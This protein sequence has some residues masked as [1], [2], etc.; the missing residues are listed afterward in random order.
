MAA[1]V[2]APMPTAP[3]RG[4]GGT[5]FDIDATA[6]AAAFAL[7]VT[8]INT[9]ASFIDTKAGEALAAALGGDLPSMAG[10]AL[11][12]LR[13]N[14]GETA[15]E[16]E[17]V[18]TISEVKSFAPKIAEMSQIRLAASKNILV[19]GAN[20]AFDVQGGWN[21]TITLFGNRIL[22][23]PTNGFSGLMGYIQVVQGSTGSRTLSFGSYYEFPGG[24]AP[25]LTATPGAIDVLFYC[26]I[27]ATRC[28]VTNVLDI[29]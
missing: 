12:F 14:A 7:L 29:S 16:F 4:D 6:F 19:D 28:L 20:V 27:S 9:S 8:E 21:A 17:D 13:V 3:D 22:D 11:Q 15:A 18:A 23:N 1:P 10:K 5:Q 24:T 25:V 26:F 2:I